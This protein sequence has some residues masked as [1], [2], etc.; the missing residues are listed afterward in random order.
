MLSTTRICSWACHTITQ[1]LGPTYSVACG[2]VILG[3][4][5]GKPQ[6]EEH[7]SMFWQMSALAWW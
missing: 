2:H 3:K 1:V 6:L 5:E 4:M 7:T